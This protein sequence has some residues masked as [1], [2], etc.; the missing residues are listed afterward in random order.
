MDSTHAADLPMNDRNKRVADT[1]ARDGGRLRNFIR[2][3]VPDPA[4]AEDILQDVLF[5]FMESYLL[6]E[7]VEQAGA[8]LFRAAR[9]RIIDRFRRKSIEPFA[10]AGSGQGDEHW[11]ESVLPSQDDGPEAAYARKVLLDE[12]YAALEALPAPQRAVFLAHE[13]EGRS[14]KDLAAESGVPLN[15]LL[16][17]KR[18]AVQSLRLRL[19]AIYDEFGIY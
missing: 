3:R 14:F 11:L 18:Y 15:T 1:V 7:T 5:A 2:R 8:W 9:N 6:P 10:D 16:A 12:I 13:V 17:R 4:D 19:Q